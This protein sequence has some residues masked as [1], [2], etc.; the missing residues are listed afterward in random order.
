MCIGFL[1]KLLGLNETDEDLKELHEYQKTGIEADTAEAET[2][3][4]ESSSE[5]IEFDEEGI[6]AQE[7]DELPEVKDVFEQGPG[8]EIETINNE[9][10]E[11]QGASDTD[12]EAEDPETEK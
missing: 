4:S 1:K 7:D 12:D 2:D 10:E 6:Y 11:V 3:E 8:N 9:N 5:E